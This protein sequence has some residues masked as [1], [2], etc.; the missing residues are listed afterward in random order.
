MVSVHRDGDTYHFFPPLFSGGNSFPRLSMAIRPHH[1][2]QALASILIVLMLSGNRL[3]AA[4]ATAVNKS[5]PRVL[6]T[7]DGG[8]NWAPLASISNLFFGVGG[9]YVNQFTDDE[10]NGMTR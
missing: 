6:Q 8:V 7:V 10:I 4:R 2:R 5:W 3:C 1:P 9:Y